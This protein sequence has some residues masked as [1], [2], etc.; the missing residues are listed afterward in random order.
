MNRAADLDSALRFVIGRIGEQAELS[1]EPL[2]DEQRLLLNNL[3]SASSGSGDPEIPELIPRNLDLE[4]VCKLA[5]A[6]Y[7]CDHQMKPSS[8]EWEFA[9]AVFMLAGHRMRGLLQLAG[10]KSPRRPWW[11]RVAL[12][13]AASLPIPAVSLALWVNGAGH[14]FLSGIVAA[15]FVVIM[16]CIFFARWR[17]ENRE[18][19]EHLERCRVAS[20]LLGQLS[21]PEQ[22]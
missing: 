14:L 10:M 22:R 17:S 1:G 2:T 3:P 19:E 8:L 13:G 21:D 9:F 5:K 11:D 16:L 4:R 20:S 15:G 18:L 12:V 6:A 7:Q